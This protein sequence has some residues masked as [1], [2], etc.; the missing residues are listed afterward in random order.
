MTS[1]LTHRLRHLREKRAWTQEE[2][3]LVADVNPRTIAR[4]ESG[5]TETPTAETRKALAQAFDM[6]VEDL[7]YPP[8]VAERAPKPRNYILEI[9][10]EGE[11]IEQRRSAFPFVV[12]GVGDEMYIEFANP[13][14]AEEYG[15]LWRVDRRRHLKF[16]AELELE[17]LMLYC[18]PCSPKW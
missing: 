2:L 17:T 16:S 1:S 18:V 14:Y 10:F 15:F 13:A 6:S 5:E 4:L 8:D 11:C 3:A 7:L 9:Y 12:P